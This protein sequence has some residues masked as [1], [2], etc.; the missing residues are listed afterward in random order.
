MK[1]FDRSSPLV[2]ELGRSI[3]AVTGLLQIPQPRFEDTEIQRLKFASA[4][5][6]LGDALYAFDDRMEE[7]DMWYERCRLIYTP[8]HYHTLSRMA[9]ALALLDGRVSDT[10]IELMH[11]SINMAA[12]SL[13][14][15]L[16]D[17][18]ALALV[19]RIRDPPPIYDD[20]TS[21]RMIGKTMLGR[22]T[23]ANA[24]Y[25]SNVSRLD[26]QVTRLM[27]AC[28]K[29]R[30]VVTGTDVQLLEQIEHTYLAPYTVGVAGEGV[31]GKSSLIS[32]LVG[33]A[34]LPVA[35]WNEYTCPTSVHNTG[36]HGFTVRVSM[37]AAV[38]SRVLGLPY[39]ADEHF[40]ITV[41]R[42]AFLRYAWADKSELPLLSLNGATA[43]DLLPGD[44]IPVHKNAVITAY[45]STVEDA[46]V[47]VN[48][49]MTQKNVFYVQEICVM[50][51][52]PLLEPGTRI[53]E[54]PSGSINGFTEAM[55]EVIWDQCDKI[56]LLHRGDSRVVDT[57]EWFLPHIRATPLKPIGVCVYMNWWSQQSGTTD[58]FKV[59]IMGAIHD[60]FVRVG[61][62]SVFFSELFVIG[63]GRE[64]K[65][66][67]KW[68]DFFRLR[69]YINPAPR[70]MTEGGKV[71]TKLM[72]KYNI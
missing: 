46:V 72:K 39:R 51:A 42:N 64:W 20:V 6:Q 24:L 47:Y 15:E 49:V 30:K 35:G 19:A 71:L 12:H 54:I 36:G 4:C 31:C 27:R 45:F 14:G 22:L 7:A 63:N 8:T 11:R 58:D 1:P 37:S 25:Y 40:D 26:S 38:V 43:E 70:D 69:D 33:A 60:M 13:E 32:R 21:D 53:V 2:A 55:E 66:D 56:V 52:F 57:M 17:R 10:V 41:R 34:V 68:D 59:A 44:R 28:A 9:A 61:D 62:G 5:A 50:G 23:Q 65:N 48:S 67:T 16:L 29:T 3:S 18:F